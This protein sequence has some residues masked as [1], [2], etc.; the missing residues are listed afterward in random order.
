MKA[1][2]KRDNFIFNNITEAEKKPINE[3]R[4]PQKKTFV[5]LRLRKM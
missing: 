4:K 5:N 2:S 1:R 3:R